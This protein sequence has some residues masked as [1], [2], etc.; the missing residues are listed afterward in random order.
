MYLR[1]T[2]IQSYNAATCFGVIYAIFMELHTQILNLYLYVPKVHLLVPR[3]N[4]LTQ[5]KH[6][7]G[8]VK[9][10]CQY[11]PMLS[12]FSKLS[13]IFQH[14]PIFYSIVQYA[15]VLSSVLSQK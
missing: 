9:V 12:I 15:I 11:C 6:R 1:Y 3:M 4:S 2:E 8:Y 5:S 10:V 14:C 7:I 13:N